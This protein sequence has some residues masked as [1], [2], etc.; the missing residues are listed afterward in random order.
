VFRNIA[1]NQRPAITKDLNAIYDKYD[2]NKKD[3]TPMSQSYISKG[4]SPAKDQ[5]TTTINIDKRNP[6]TSA[7]K[8]SLSKTHKAQK[9]TIEL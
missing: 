1:K 7:K 2:S 6:P 5:K 4:N 3:S 9:S 8:R